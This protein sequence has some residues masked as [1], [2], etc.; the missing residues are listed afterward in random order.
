MAPN[1]TSNSTDNGTL[2]VGGTVAAGPKQVPQ[3]N[4]AIYVSDGLI[5]EVGPA[6]E[7][8]ARHASAKVTD[9]AGAT[10]LPGLT[11]AHGHLYSLGQ[12]LDTV[13][14]METQS[15]D[16]VIARVRERAARAQPG[17]WILGRGWDQND[18]PVKEFPTAAQLD[19]ALPNNPVWITR[20]DGH[21]GLANT[22][23]LRA[24]GVLANVQDPEGGKVLR[25]PAGAPSGVFIDAAQDLVE[26]AI[27][28]PTFAQ[29]KARVLASA[30]QIAKNGLT[31]MHDAGADDE[32]IRAI[33]ELIDENQFPIRVYVMLSD[34][35]KLLET[36]L[37]KGPLV[38]YGGHLTVRAIKAYADGAL[39]S[40]GAAL[41]APY[42][43]DPTNTGLMLATTEHLEQV[44]RRALAGGF[45]LNT[46][47]IGD[48]GTRNVIDAY[49]RAGTSAKYRFRI[50]H[51]QVIAPSDI[52]RL[53]QRGIIAS[54][55][56]T[57]ATS[58]MYWAEQRLGSERILG[59]YAWRTVLD[60]GGRLALGSDFPVED[61][62]PF[63]G[64]HAAVTRQDKKNWPEGGWYPKQ[65][66]TLAEAV[67]GFTSDAAY[68]AFEEA[69]R[70]T[71]E[72]GKLA[73]FTIVEGDFYTM[74]VSDLWKT[75]VRQ[76]VVG[77]AIVYD[78][79]TR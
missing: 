78:A 22:A 5:R 44:A 67:R 26:R 63:F 31:E 68:A 73:D 50:E 20:V 36:W 18:W 48:R 23:A 1:T 64:I 65:R 76:T 13:N 10:I 2:F 39:G 29:V 12:S 37:Q 25:D 42:S 17:E 8:R 58:D 69:S 51:L 53:V 19:A 34:D 75:K 32:T 35:A 21:A 41:L 43:D 71:I 66:L 52:P 4:F 38:D 72:P 79:N 56:P 15:L 40:R 33:R 24:A 54:M 60:A 7:L 3:K 61:V 45:Q 9:A 11:D 16:E 57:H 74:P 6:A 30:Q 59:A 70:G 14:L 28:K 49:E 55:Q 77:G 27:P 47:A 62:N 46:H